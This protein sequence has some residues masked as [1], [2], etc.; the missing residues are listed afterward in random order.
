[1]KTKSTLYENF[2]TVKKISFSACT[3]VPWEVP[4]A[5]LDLSIEG[6]EVIWISENI[7]D[8]YNLEQG[9]DIGVRLFHK[10]GRVKRVSWLYK[11]P[12]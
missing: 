3:G 11:N 1:M 6:I 10:N 12:S 2:A 4:V 9:D 8:K 5:T 7:I